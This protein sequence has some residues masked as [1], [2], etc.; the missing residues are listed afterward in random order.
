MKDKIYTGN[1]LLDRLSSG[2]YVNNPNYNP[3]TKAGRTRPSVLVDTSAGDIDSGGF[4]STIDKVKRLQFTGK[5]L[6]KTNED[7]EYDNKYNITLSPYNSE[8]ELNKA[9]AEAQSSFAKFGNF[10]MQAGV[11][12]IILGTLEG[13]GNI[14]D[15]VINSFTGDN[16]DK[17]AYTEF[18]HEAKENLNNKFKINQANPNTSWDISDFGWWMQNAVSV[19]STAS[20][21]LPAAG[22]ARGISYAGK[23]TNLNKIGRW[24]TKGVSRGIAKAATSVTNNSSRFSA[25]K[26]VAGK[27]GRIEETI[28]NGAAITNQAILSRAGENYMEAKAIYDDVY[29]NSKENLDNM[30]DDEFNKFIKFNPNFKDLSKDEIAKEIAKQSANKTF[31]NDWFMLAFDI[32]QFKALGKLWGK[33]GK[34]SS[35]AFERIAAENVKRTMAG[36]SSD[37]LIKNNILNR[38]KEGIK[39]SL[40]NP[41]KSLVSLELDE[42]VEELYQGIQSEKGMEVAT[43]YFDENFTSRS[44]QSYLNDGSM[45][46]QFFWG[47]LGGVAFNKIGKGVKHISNL[48]ENTWNKKHMTAEDYENWKRSEDKIAIE[49]INNITERSKQFVQ[50]MEQI[51]KNINPYNY[52]IDENTGR[53]IIKNGK[54]VQETI[55]DNEKEL[56]KEEAIKRFIDKTTVDAVDNGTFDLIKEI[57]GSNEFDKFIDDNG[58]KITSADKIL[59]QQVVDR[60]NEVSGIYLSAL[61][62]VTYSADTT[63]PYITRAAARNITANKLIIDDYNLQL[64]NILNQINELNDTGADYSRFIEKLTYN[65]IQRKLNLLQIRRDKINSDYLNGKISKSAKDRYLSEIDRDTNFLMNLAAYTT[66][67]GTLDSVKNYIKNNKNSDEIIKQF[68]NFTNEFNKKLGDVITPPTTINELIE[69][70]IDV[71]IKRSFTEAQIPTSAKEYQELYNEF[72]I[73][74]DKM[75]IDKVSDYIDIVK[76]YLR[77][78]DD[79]DTALKQVMKENTNDKKVNEALNYLKFGYYTNDYNSGRTK[80]Q[81]SIN[82]QFNTIIDELRKERQTAEERKEEAKRDNTEIPKGDENIADANTT[83]PFTGDESKTNSANTADTDNAIRT[84]ENITIENNISPIKGE[85]SGVITTSEPVPIVDTS[86][87]ID[88]N[89]VKSDMT[90]KELSENAI[91]AAGYETDNI[92]ADLDARRY[93]MQIGFKESGRIDDITNSL[94]NGNKSKYDDF[95]KEITDFLIDRGYNKQLADNIAKNAF[96][97]T[98]ASFAAM[99]NKNA[100]GRLAQQLAIGFEEDSAKKFS[101]TELID[102]KGIDKV[103]DNF[104][105]EYNKLVGNSKFNDTQSIINVESLFDYIINDENIDIITANYIYNN[106]SKFISTHDNSKY[107]FTGFTTN[108]KMLSAEQFF[109]RLI[110]NKAQVVDSVNKM[111]IHAIENSNR[112]KNYIDAIIAAAN[113]ANSYAK[114]ENTQENESSNIYIYVDIKKGNKTI[115]VKIG[116]LR[117]VNVSPDL[118][119]ITPK[120]HKSGFKNSIEVK[121]DGEISLDCDFIFNALINERETNADAKQL[122]DDLVQYYVNIQTIVNKLNSGEIDDRTANAELNKAIDADMEFRILNSSLIQTLVNNE[123]YKFYD[124][125]DKDLNSRV[126][127]IAK[128]ISSI[129]FYGTG[130]DASD[131]TNNKVNTMAI[132]NR[133]MTNRYK[134]WK[135][136]IYTNYLQTYELQ[137]NLSDT[138][139]KVEINVNAGYYTYLNEIK[140][141]SEY[142]NIADAGFDI[143]PNSENYTPLIIVNSQNRM[144]DEF[145]NDYGFA[146]SSINPYSMGFIV[147]NEDNIKLVGYCNTAQDISNSKIGAAVKNELYDILIKQLYNTNDETHEDVYNDIKDRLFELFG[148]GGL[149][150]FN[151]NNIRILAPKDGSYITIA[152]KNENGVENNII[153]IFRKNADNVTNSHAI[154]VYV[155]KLNKQIPINAL[156]NYKSKDGVELNEQEIKDAIINS[157]N[158][159]MSSIKLN[160]SMTAITNKTI[161]GGTSNIFKRENGKFIVTL[162]NKSYTYESYADFI[163]QN[164]GF[165]TN[166][167]GTTNN[168]VTRV[169]NENRITID[170]KVLDKSGISRNHNTNVSDLLINTKRKRITIDTKDI[171]EAAGINKDKI[172]ILLG[173]NSK[174]PIVSKTIKISDTDDGETNAYYNTKDKYIYITPKGAASMNNNP[175]NAIRII[176]HENLH[177]LFHIQNNYNQKERDRIISDLKEVYEYTIKQ[178]EKDKI[179]GN[180]KENIYNDIISVLNKATSYDN[181]QINMEEFLMECLTQ[182]VIVEY[183]N[184][185][186]YHSEVN[187]DNINKKKKSIFQKIIDI[188][189]DLLGIKSNRIKNNSI[190]AREYIILSKTSNTANNGLFTEKIKNKETSIT[191]ENLNNTRNQ[192]NNIRKWFEKRIV[193]SENFIKDHTY[194]IDGKPADYSVTQKIHGKQDIGSFSVP[195]SLLGN[196]ADDAAR[197]YFKNNGHIPESHNIPNV[198]NDD[199]ENSKITIERDISKIKEYLDKKFGVGKYEVITEEFPIGGVV[200]V[201]NEEKTIAGIMDM[202]VY[203]DTGDIYIFDFKTK[204]IGSGDGSIAEHTLVGYKQQVNIY[205]QL[206]EENYPELK[207]KIHTGGLIKF[208]TDY[209]APGPNAEYRENPEIP[210][211]LQFRENSTDKFINIQDSSADYLAPFFYGDEDFEKAHIINVEQQN[212]IEKIKALPKLE[213]TEIEV[214]IAGTEM[215]QTNESDNLTFD[216]SIFDKDYDFG[217]EY[218]TDDIPVFKSTTELIKNIEDEMQIILNNAKRDNQ[219][220][221][222]A[223][224]G[225]PSNLTEKQY[226]QVRTKAF[227]E[228]FGDWEKIANIQKN[229]TWTDEE[230]NICAKNGY[231]NNKFSKGGT[232]EIVKE[233]KGASHEYGGIDIEIFNNTIRMSRKNGEFKAKYGVI[234]KNNKNE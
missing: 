25:L 88:D 89:P 62:D 92:K 2:P 26:S 145:G 148:P 13:F 122:F 185:T 20:L 221:L 10:L 5:D 166:V 116:I 168:F 33:G 209:P 132:D 53:K 140:N 156:S 91:V 74:M 82:L 76:K 63:N 19:A 101:I 163:L 232:W 150:V 121:S 113:G 9:R 70:Q 153:S 28:K 219:G 158:T 77:D 137:K 78:A 59:S 152:V 216:P 29:T 71:Q 30:P 181:E 51:N 130:F 146:D 214:D 22:W 154:S 81:M 213:K 16:Y 164:R 72:A 215:I 119:I 99:N 134:E 38:T 197:I 171:L 225:K 228:W 142:V 21:L 224:N 52:V 44:L 120:S 49:Q 87:P 210:N 14:A 186:D 144:I 31:Y 34:R 65:S 80:A 100:F 167:N 6:G 54:L 205:R 170:S 109:N 7:I 222:L 204:R 67:D 64:D 128:S 180:I 114:L 139:K 106:L 45:W 211:Q 201:N 108:G 1:N 149:F 157:I 27:A 102:G 37:E 124:E 90:N 176:L 12:E 233:F 110:E 231:T 58:V 97:S 118:K 18:M 188:L 190:L 47:S 66:T 192:I 68:N 42:G 173:V 40:T 129:L 112:D 220:R 169:L 174:M 178:L 155:P 115:P 104:L 177:R 57:L 107:I 227:K 24:A 194:F 94:I 218:D 175:T 189:L 182:P 133:T 50:E 95:I 84:D 32:A 199:G 126:R 117:G 125:G 138:D 73:S 141:P 23:I 11:G 8:E 208:L 4:T 195:S 43:Y 226:A 229:I 36:K 85:Q 160:R 56:L 39:Y 230:G 136:N 131:P 202:L 41:T 198:T 147:H 217:D 191:N 223:P 196:T 123:I 103:V 161:S 200:V 193:R 179:S 159:V 48:I 143:D 172:D 183:L 86:I 83:N 93:V 212:Y 17:N 46:E 35:T 3:K 135:S 184:N 69:Q 96:T 234:I 75:L 105:D 187:I 203:T 98:V 207:G 60:M 206:I 15:G 127:S 55:N 111:H 61:K 165:N 79:F 162:G 151:N